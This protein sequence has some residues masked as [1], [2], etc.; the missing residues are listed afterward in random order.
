MLRGSYTLP[1]AIGLAIQPGDVIRTGGTAWAAILFTD[2]SQA[3]VAANSTLQIKQVSPPG[4]TNI[5]PT[6]GGGLRTILQ[7]FLGESWLHTMSPAVELELETPT[8]TAA[9]KG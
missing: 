1:A 9:I 6:L 3:K 7:F 8:A 4:R 5:T 2:G